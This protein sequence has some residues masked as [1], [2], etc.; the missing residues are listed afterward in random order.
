MQTKLITFIIC[1]NNELYYEECVYYIN[2][3]IIPKGYNIDIVA[4]HEADSMCAA[5]NAG[6]QSNNAK[7]K[8]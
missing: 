4:I 3:L 2:R 5:Y 7:Y 6:M 8:I 1:V